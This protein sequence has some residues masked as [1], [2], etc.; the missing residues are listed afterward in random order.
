MLPS[1]TATAE[2]RN[3]KDCGYSQ[4]QHLGGF[5]V[6]HVRFQG[7]APVRPCLLKRFVS[8][9][10]TEI[11]KACSDH[12]PIGSPGSHLQLTVRTVPSTLREGREDT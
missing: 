11:A 7:K 8:P 2:T 4:A 12:A 5:A 6:K 1:L 9:G 3:G 10:K